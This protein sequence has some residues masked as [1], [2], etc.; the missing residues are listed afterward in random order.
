MIELLAKAPDKTSALAYLE[1]V[2][3]SDMQYVTAEDWGGDTSAAFHFN[4]RFAFED[5]KQAAQ[6]AASAFGVSF[7]DP[8]AIQTRENVWA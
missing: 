7:I 6:D 1:A 5:S 4:M 8:A 3:R 2:A